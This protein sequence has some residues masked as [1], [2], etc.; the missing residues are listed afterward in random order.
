MILKSN[1]PFIFDHNLLLILPGDNA[2]TP[3]LELKLR[4]D[5]KIQQFMSNGKILFLQD[6]VVTMIVEKEP[7]KKT[8]IPEIPV[9][10]PKEDT[11]EGF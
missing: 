9:F 1:L 3:E 10:V 11:E 5:S 2:V 4:E 7:E 6:A 8:I